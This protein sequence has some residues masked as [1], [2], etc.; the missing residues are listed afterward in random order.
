[1]NRILHRG[2]AGSTRW[3]RCAPVWNKVIIM[4]SWLTARGTEALS[5]RL[6]GTGGCGRPIDIGEEGLV[7]S[8]TKRLARREDLRGSSIVMWMLDDGTPLLRHGGRSVDACE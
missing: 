7:E 5:V 3:K 1:M 2:R 6:L 8:F 4:W